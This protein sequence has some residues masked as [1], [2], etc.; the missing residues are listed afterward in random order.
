MREIKKLYLFTFFRS[1]TFF[2]AVSVAF[3]CD[4]G[5]SYFQIMVLQ[6]IYGI[7]T[8]IMELPS[9]ILSDVVGRKITLIIGTICFFLAYLC[10]ATGSSM[11]LFCLMQILAAV[12]QSCYS[13]TFVSLMYEDV[14]DGDDIRKSVNV[15]FANMQS[16]N[17]FSVL[18]ASLMSSVIVRYEGMRC[19]YYC[20]AFAY[21]VTLII[22]IFLSENRQL[23][24]TEKGRISNYR[25]EMKK[26]L[27]V[28]RENGLVV[29]MIDM[30]IIASFANT[31][32]YMQQPILIANGLNVEYFGIVMFVMTVV[33]I[34]SLKI[35]PKIE[36]YVTERR[37]VF[38][39]LAGIAM[40]VSNF[41]VKM[42][43]WSVFTFI[44]ITIIVRFREIL[45][46]NKIN[47]FINNDAR[48]TTM[49][50]ISAL[51]MVTLAVMSLLI[52]LVEDISL[53]YAI[54]LLGVGVLFL[55]AIVLFLRKRHCQM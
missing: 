10:G 19:T 20:T 31:F 14:K 40:V 13:G 37:I 7:A 2:S 3:Y 25:N 28:I 53:S 39:T 35:M 34:L 49:S 4:N 9:G 45:L 5:L 42:Y 16:I 51:Q 21:L 38:F 30:V 15:I 18:L 47:S 55:Y 52:G 12:G 36:K 1:L 24:S 50:I 32:S 11:L 43:I 8:A 44:F 33:T 54:L 17:I 29:V 6:T 46:T 22:S 23:C 48:A 41:F 27:G 26:S